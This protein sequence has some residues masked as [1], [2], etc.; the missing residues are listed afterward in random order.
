M[1]G[2]RG[3]SL[4]LRCERMVPLWGLS[5]V[6]LDVST[7]FTLSTGRCLIGLVLGLGR[8]KINYKSN[9]RNSFGVLGTRRDF[10]VSLRIEVRDS[11]RHLII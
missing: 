3:V 1:L 7:L 11:S 4:A 5:E 6:S 2:G 10:R 9:S 8:T